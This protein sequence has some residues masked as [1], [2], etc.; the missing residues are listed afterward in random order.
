MKN[1]YLKEM[2][3]VLAAGLTKPDE[4]GQNFRPILA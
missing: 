3:D 1:I 2:C 4:G